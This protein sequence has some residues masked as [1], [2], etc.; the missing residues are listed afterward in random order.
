MVSAGCIQAHHVI[1]LR[2]TEQAKFLG[3]GSKVKDG[4]FD[5]FVKE[6][7]CDIVGPS[8]RF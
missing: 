4:N 7:G 3:D 8:G 1:L 5:K 2:T 6:K